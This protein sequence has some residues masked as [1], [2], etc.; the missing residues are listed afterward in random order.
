MRRVA[1]Y[2]MSQGGYVYGTEKGFWFTGRQYLHGR[3]FDGMENT[4]YFREHAIERLPDTVAL[5]R[6]IYKKAGA[7]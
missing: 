5:L 2:K 4:I 3:W 6:G 1:C 7:K